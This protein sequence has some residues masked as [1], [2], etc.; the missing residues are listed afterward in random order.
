MQLIIF[1]TILAYFII[2]SNPNGPISA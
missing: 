2:R 1:S